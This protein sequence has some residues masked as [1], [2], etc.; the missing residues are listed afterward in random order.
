MPVT[1]PAP[2]TQPGYTPLTEQERLHNY[3]NS[4]IG[5][6]NFVTGALSAGW[7]QMRDRPHE[8]PQGAEGFGLRMG[9]GYA[10]RVT[11]ETLMYGSSALLH[12]DNRYIHST[13]TTTGGRLRYAVESTF[14]AHREDGTRTFSSSRIGSM[15]G[16]SLISRTWQPPSTGSINSTFVNFGTALALTAGFNVVREF[17]PKKFKFFR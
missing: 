14:L 16:A 17:M 3:V 10:Q 13:A 6:M 5:P 15:L 12:Q 4:L 7:G 2:V 1:A 8:W 9:S 11:R